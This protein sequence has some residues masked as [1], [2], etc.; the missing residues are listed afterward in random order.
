MAATPV[1]TCV[2]VADAAARTSFALVRVS[3]LLL[4]IVLLTTGISDLFSDQMSFL[5]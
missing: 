3:A 1:R 4:F 2:A 5:T